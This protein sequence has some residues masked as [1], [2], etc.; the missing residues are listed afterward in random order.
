MAYPN[1]AKF[2]PPVAATLPPF[3]PDTKGIELRLA[4]YRN[5]MNQGVTVYSLSDGSFV[6]DF[7]TAENSNTAIPPYPAM[8]DQ[9]TTPNV[10]AVNYAGGTP[11]VKSG[12]RTVTTISPYVLNGGVYYGGRTYTVSQTVATNLAAYTAHGT[13]YADCLVAL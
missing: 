5:V 2:T 7:P 4:R 12:T 13:G 1:G 3:T 9:G 10:I 8:P 11:T 6:Q